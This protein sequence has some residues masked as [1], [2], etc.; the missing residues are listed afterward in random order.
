MFKRARWVAIGFGAGIG[1]SVY[2]YRSVRKTVE[3]HTTPELRDAGRKV[4][5][6]RR[7]M[8]AAVS[9]GREAMREREAELN[10][11]ISN[12]NGVGHP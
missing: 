12:G 2:T 10:A 3:R 8:Q 4:N 1:A 9:E 11:R 7:D 6:L 5:S